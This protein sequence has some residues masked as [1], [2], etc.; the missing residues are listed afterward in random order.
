MLSSNFRPQETLED[1]ISEDL[2]RSA[3]S[4]RI[5]SSRSLEKRQASLRWIICPIFLLA[6]TLGEAFGCLNLQAEQRVLERE[7]GEV[8]DS[9][10][11][12]GE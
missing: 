10:T 2:K 1:V 6:S 7:R 3:S 12:G 9:P 8:R 4:S 5:P 11:L